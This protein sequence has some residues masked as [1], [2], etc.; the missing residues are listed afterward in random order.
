MSCARM[1]HML[2]K[3]DIKQIEEIVQKS[4]KNAFSEFYETIFEP[5]VNRNEKE[6][7]EIR[8]EIR[9]GIVGIGEYIKDHE[10]RIKKLESLNSL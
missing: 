10:K 5:Y 9:E 6:H 2:T 4:I 1:N 7:A 8:K 3:K